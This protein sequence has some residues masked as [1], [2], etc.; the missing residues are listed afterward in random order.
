MCKIKLYNGDCLEVMDRLIE[1]GVKV[2]AIITDPPYKTI[3]GGVSIKDGMI[4]SDGTNCSNKWLK[5]DKGSMP[6][7]LKNGT[8][9]KHNKITFNEWIPK[10]FNILNDGGHLYIMANDRNIN[11]VINIAEKSKFKLLN[12]L[13]WKK[14]NCT[15]NK[16]YMKNCEFI[17]F[18]RKGFAKSINNMG[19]K[20]VIEVDNII[21][22]KIHPSEK[23]I[24]L[25]EI[26]IENSTNENE[27]VLDPFMG[28]GSTGIAC[29]NLNRN[30]I[31][32]ELDEE[33]FKI[34]E[35]RINN[36]GEKK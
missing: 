23:P 11:E 4:L 15:P 1:E 35:E 21:G 8:Q 22:N 29:K 28:G 27:I 20:T 34:A 9:L 36:K 26:L 12:L 13:V 25:M 33:Y 31:G 16:Y 7:T 14:Q 19:T 6:A 32:I 2:D 5:K 17:A 3:S 18:F 24:E 30:F 10:L